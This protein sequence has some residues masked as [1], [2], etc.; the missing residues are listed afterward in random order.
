MK[1]LRQVL[2]VIV[3]FGVIATATQ[4]SSI[5][6]SRAPSTPGSASQVQL[7]W[8]S[9]NSGGLT[10]QSSTNF[11]AG[12]SCGQTCSGAGQS[13]NFKVN[14]GFWQVGVT[15]LSLDMQEIVAEVL[16][17]TYSL[18]QNYPNPFNPSTV[19]EF[20]VPHRSHVRLSIHNL[21][22]QRV[23]ALV[24]ESMSP[25]VYQTAWHGCD[26][27]GNQVASGIYFYRLQAD[28]FVEAKKMVLL[29]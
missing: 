16:P 27:A 2:I 13:T 25:G 15:S 5:E 26:E 3:G 20:T 21:L 29:K 1:Q 9:V 19:I 8:L 7:V 28:Q 18:S 17:T 24:D 6:A 14:F 22:G 4:A 11:T 12:L 23:A 10:E